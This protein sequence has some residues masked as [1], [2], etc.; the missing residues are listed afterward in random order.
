VVGAVVPFLKTHKTRVANLAIVDKHREALPP[1]ERQFWMWPNR[2]LETLS[3]ANVVFISGAA[4]V[5]GG[6]D[7]LLK[8]SV[9]ARQVMLVGPTT[10]LWGAPFFDR[11]VSALVGMRVHDHTQLLRLVTEGGS[12]ELFE[13]AADNV[14]LMADGRN[15]GKAA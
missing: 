3:H 14:T 13:R 12:S 11:G 15:A 4:L 8:A 2:T 7:D 9:A 10:P 5:E 6:I 1:E